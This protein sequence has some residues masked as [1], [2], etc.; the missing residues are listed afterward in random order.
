[1]GQKMNF[2]KKGILKVE[3]KFQGCKMIAELKITLPELEK[4]HFNEIHFLTHPWGVPGVNFSTK[5]KVHEMLLNSH[6][7]SQ[8]FML[9]QNIILVSVQTV[10]S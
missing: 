1:M 3:I 5:K 8:F 7:S 4:Q 10:L 9:I 6:S 2:L